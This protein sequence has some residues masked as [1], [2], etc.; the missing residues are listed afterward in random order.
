MEKTAALDW[1]S[2]GITRSSGRKLE[3]KQH[4]NFS[5]TEVKC[6]FFLGVD[7]VESLSGFKKWVV[8]GFEFAD[9]KFIYFNIWSMSEI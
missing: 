7:D 5:E 9:R 1:N 2:R 8:S 4:K 3:E 6:R